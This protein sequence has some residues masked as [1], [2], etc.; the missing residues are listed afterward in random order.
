MQIL[1]DVLLQRP[2]KCVINDSCLISH[3]TTCKKG[4]AERT[5]TWE[6]SS[7]QSSKASSSSPY[8]SL[9]VKIKVKLSLYF[10]NYTF[11]CYIGGGGGGV[12]WGP[13][14]IAATN[15]PIVPA[16]GDYDDG[17]IGGMIGRGNRSTRRKPAPMP[18]ALST[19]NP[20]CCPDA[21]PGHRGGS[22]PCNRP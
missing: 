13:L 14:G 5:R 3:Q 6:Y 11:N 15:R 16:A 19:T 2:E 9:Q 10:F 12:Q 17:E 18:L 22:Y 4:K 7:C 8:C 1:R 20:T 21:N